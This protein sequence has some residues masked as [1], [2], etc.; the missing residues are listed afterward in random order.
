[1]AK[2]SK[3][4][5]HVPLGCWSNQYPNAIIGAGAGNSGE[6]II[7]FLV[8]TETVQSDRPD[9]DRFVV[10]RIVGQYQVIGAETE[11]A[12]YMVHHRVYVA[13][14]DSSSI[15]LRNLGTA[16]EAET[17]FLWHQVE[18][19]N[20]HWNNGVFGNWA[21]GNTLTPTTRQFMGRMGHVDIRVGR[22]IEGGQ[23]LCWHTQFRG[24]VA[25]ED[26]EFDICFWL[27]ILVRHG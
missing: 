25:P 1:L 20:V 22:A 17:S 4:F 27:R 9:I 12:P 7:Q 13:D 15:A 5:W 19:W 26:D 24:A 8:D 10:E 11:A 3:Y 21:G 23:I 6:D 14:A 2:K 18:T 16:D